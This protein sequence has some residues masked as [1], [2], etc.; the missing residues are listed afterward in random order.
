MP[1]PIKPAI[2]AELDQTPDW[3]DSQY[4]QLERRQISRAAADHEGHDIVEDRRY[5]ST[6]INRTCTTCSID[7]DPYQ[8]TS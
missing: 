3:W 2:R 4:R 1:E 7:L 6:T 5:T 8:E